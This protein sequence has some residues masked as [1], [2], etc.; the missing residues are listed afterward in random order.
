MRRFADQ[1]HAV[2]GKTARRR[3]RQRKDLRPGSTTTR[4]SIDCMRSSIFRESASSIE[5]CQRLRDV[6]L[7]DPDQTR[8]VAGQR[9]LRERA[10][11]GMEF[12]RDRPV[13]PAMARM[14]APA[15]IA[16]MCGRILLCRRRRVPAT[17]A[18]RRPRRARRDFL[19]PSASVAATCRFV[20]IPIGDEAFSP[21]QCVACSTQRRPERVQIAVGDIQP[22]MPFADLAGAKSHDRTSDEAV[23]RVDDAHRFQRCRDSPDSVAKSKTLQQFQRW[24]HECRGAA[25]AV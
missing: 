20:E 10:G 6:G 5:F 9:N 18:R 17:R 1:R 11:F 13:R 25:I 4:P 24:H 23:R 7:D 2:L 22:E 15:P 3:G 12:G 21:M 19:V 8:S 14:S 16:A